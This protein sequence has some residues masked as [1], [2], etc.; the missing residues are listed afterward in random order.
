M[1]GNSVPFED[2][3]RVNWQLCRIS[4]NDPFVHPPGFEITS[5]VLHFSSRKISSPSSESNLSVLYSHGLSHQPRRNR[6]SR[7]RKIPAGIFC[8]KKENM[9]WHPTH[10]T[11][12]L[13]GTPAR[14]GAI[15]APGNAE[16]R[17]KDDG[18]PFPERARKTQENS[19]D[20]I[21]MV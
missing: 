9:A 18:L 16:R 20:K 7:R 21:D 2:F 14:W 15:L 1:A 19:M 11:V 8:G 5:P 3:R 13:H 6:I 4:E 12:N 17:R 10:A